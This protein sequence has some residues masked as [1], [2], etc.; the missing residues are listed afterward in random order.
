MWTAQPRG[1]DRL[2]A[3]LPAALRG[4][5]AA[6]VD[7]TDPALAR[8]SLEICRRLGIPTI[9][10]TG[11]YRESSDAYLADADYIIAPEKYFV[12]RH[13]SET[14]EAAMM[15]VHDDFGPT[16][17]AATRGDQGG[18][19]LDESGY[20]SYRAVPVTARDSSGAGDAF[21]GAFAWAIAAGA[22]VDMAI[23]VAAWVAAQKCRGTG[24]STLPNG[25]SLAAFLAKLGESSGLA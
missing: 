25:E 18:L 16:V 8:S 19:Y 12:A 2:L 9:I 7:C 17:L 3:A 23:R 11:S 24:N 1:D 21:H 14:L 5:D 20:R 13:P 10:D 15:K 4:A 22:P 6:L